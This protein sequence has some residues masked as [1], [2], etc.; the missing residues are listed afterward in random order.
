MQATAM[1]VEDLRKILDKCKP[2]AEVDLFLNASMV[3][4][5]PKKTDEGF[6]YIHSQVVTTTWADKEC[7]GLADYLNIEAPPGI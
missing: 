7:T 4:R 6:E 3:D 1:K 2:D 5:E